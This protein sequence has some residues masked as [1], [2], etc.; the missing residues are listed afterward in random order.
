MHAVLRSLWRLG[1]I[2]V[3]PVATARELRD[4]E[5]RWDGLVIGLL[6]LLGTG[7]FELLRGV[8]T[9]R[10]TANLSGA[11]MFAAALGRVLLVPILVLVVCE[12]ILGQARGHRRGLMLAPL[13]LVAVVA[14]E[15][16]VHGVRLGAYVPPIVGGVLS[17]GLTWWVRSELRPLAEAGDGASAEEEGTT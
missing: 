7:G 13:L 8:A 6:Y 5:G 4:D 16:A 10:A 1:G 3:A 14:H 17:V 2:L 15:L 12:T 9:V 11:L